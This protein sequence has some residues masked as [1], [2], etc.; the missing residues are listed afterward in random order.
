MH[1]FIGTEVDDALV[2]AGAAAW[3]GLIGAISLELFGH[4]VNAVSDHD[5]YFEQLLH[6]LAPTGDRLATH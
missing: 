1:E 4:L 2:M 5:A 3:S 6:V